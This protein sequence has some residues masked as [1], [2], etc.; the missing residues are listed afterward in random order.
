MT[1]GVVR[2][3]WT[4]SCLACWACIALI[5]P[6]AGCTAASRREA[7]PL[8]Y[9]DATPVG[10]ARDIMYVEDARQESAG[11]TARLLWRARQAAAGSRLAP[12]R[13][14]AGAGRAP[15]RSFRL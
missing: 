11:G 3:D 4:K 8:A 7:P 5:L 6:L 12:A 10:F 1:V 9:A 2:L 15:G 14:W 13:W